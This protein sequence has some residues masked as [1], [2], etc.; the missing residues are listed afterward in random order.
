[1]LTSRADVAT[2]HASRYLQQLCKH[3]AHKFPV[4]FDPH[5]G[6]IQL[7]LGRTVMDADA[8]ALHI[9]VAADDAATLERLETVVADHIKRFAFREELTFDWKQAPSE[10]A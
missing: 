1:M 8:A 7:S 9:A 5:H 3:W 6:A 10:A 2:E 4:E